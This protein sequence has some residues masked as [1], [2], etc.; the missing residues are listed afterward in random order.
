MLAVAV[1]EVTPHTAGTLRLWVLLVVAVVAQGETKTVRATKPVL[2]QRIPAVAAGAAVEPL[3]A[4]A[5]Q[6]AAAQV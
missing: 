3:T 1:V 5:I 6:A 2:G 4:A